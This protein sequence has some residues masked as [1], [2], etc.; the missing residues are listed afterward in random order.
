MN[1]TAP[2]HPP[3]RA[4]L[5]YDPTATVPIEYRQPNALIVYGRADSLGPRNPG[6]AEAA[7]AGALGLIY[8]DIT[9]RNTF[10]RYSGLFF[11][12]SAHGAAIPSAGFGTSWGPAAD[13]RVSHSVAKYKSVL[14]Q[15]ADEHPYA[16]GIFADDQGPNW[17]GYPGMSASMREAFYQAQVAHALALN[18]VATE[19]GW[20][21]LCTNGMWD[22]RQSQTGGGTLGGFGYPNRNR[23]GCGLFDIFCQENMNLDDFQRCYSGETLAACG[24]Q[25]PA[26]WRTRD[27]NG[28]CGHFSL[29]KT[30]AQR[31]AYASD[32]TFNCGWGSMQGDAAKHQQPLMPPTF[33]ARDIGLGEAPP[34][35]G[36]A[37]PLAP[38]SITANADGTF[39]VE[40]PADPNRA[41]VIGNLRTNAHGNEQHP[42]WG[43]GAPYG[44]DQATMDDF[45]FFATD[46]GTAKTVVCNPRAAYGAPNGAPVEGAAKHYRVWTFTPDMTPLPFPPVSITG[47]ARI[48]YSASVPFTM[49][50]P[51][52]SPC[53]ECEAALDEANVQIA[54]RDEQITM[55]IGQRDMAIS[56]RDAALST[57]AQVR[58][59]VA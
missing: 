54:L 25:A 59:L 28:R 34:P 29:F 36:G 38:T 57:I 45:S 43:E 35:P 48:A 27:P 5:I 49:P 26:Q 41:Y 9:V 31:D 32:P 39:T 47:D 44:A 7:A 55:L 16:V 17:S 21:W 24:A 2:F 33:A 4:T 13:L 20:R 10:G 18:E 40:L 19:R 56:E 22:G 15:L 1:P 51:A 53:A 37:M 6:A 8:F 12:A 14:R 23:H 42:Y 58:A 30:T 11:D 46:D 3:Q 52:A 50:A